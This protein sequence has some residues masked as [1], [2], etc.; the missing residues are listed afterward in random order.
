M[1]K[2]PKGIPFL[3]III[4]RLTYRYG[5]LILTVVSVITMFQFFTGSESIFGEMGNKISHFYYDYL[6]LS[7]LIL[8]FWMATFCL[9]KYFSYKL[10]VPTFANI[11]LI[12]LSTASAF[13]FFSMGGIIGNKIFLFISGFLGSFIS[14]FLSLFSALYFIDH[15]YKLNYTKRLLNKYFPQKNKTKSSSARKKVQKD[16]ESHKNDSTNKTIE[17]NMPPTISLNAAF[18][19]ET[20]MLKRGG[21]KSY[22]LPDLNCFNVDDEDSCNEDD[23]SEKIEQAFKD[24]GLSIKVV[25]QNFGPMVVTYFLEV[26]SGTKLSKINSSLPDIGVKLG[27]SSESLRLNSAASASHDGIGVEVPRASRSMLYFGAMISYAKENF[28]K[29]NIPVCIGISSLG[30][31]VVR[32]LTNFPHIMLAGSTGSGKSVALNVLIMSIISIRKASEVQLVLIDPKAVE[33][34]IYQALPNLLTDVISETED[35]VKCLSQ[36]CSIMDERYKILKQNNVRN[37]K[38]YQD[39]SQ[40]GKLKMPYIVV[41]IDEL[42]DLIME[43]GKDIEN[44]VGRLAQKARAAGIHLVLATQRPTADIIK[45][46]IKTNVSG[47]LA[48]R[49]SSRVDSEVILGERGAESLFG[50]GDCLLSEID[51]KDLIRLQAPYIDIGEI[52]KFCSQF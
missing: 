18:H 26:E 52:K 30:E 11:A 6:N 25:S 23:I 10:I 51:S 13:S 36:L 2:L 21:F 22:T 27:F 44:S 16:N 8:I 47:R 5:V 45:G 39:I 28:S 35:A 20:A 46:L 37:I 34:S 50:K 41:V 40:G 31:K 42:G 17:K 4:R 38:E 48:F 29:S 3:D 33:F 49:V 9:K 24:F 43:G 14:F 32:D 1:L 19:P 12:T 15:A 7:S